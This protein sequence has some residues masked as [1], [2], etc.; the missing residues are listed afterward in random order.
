M[1][2]AQQDEAFSVLDRDGDGEVSF[3]E[4]EGWWKGMEAENLMAGMAGDE[5]KA[6][7]AE[8]GCVVRDSNLGHQLLLPPANRCPI[9][10]VWTT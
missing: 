1:T 5:V 8:A 4:F 10:A 3:E 7:L 6:A 2:A 9:F